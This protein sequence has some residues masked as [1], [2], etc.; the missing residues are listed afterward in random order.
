MCTRETV[1]MF[2]KRQRRRAG[3][4]DYDYW[5]LVRT[6]RS[7]RGPRHEVVARLGKLDGVEQKAARGWHDLDALLEGRSV[8]RQLEFGENAPTPLWRQVNL[9]QVRVERVRQF[10]RVYLG[11][12][13]WRRLKLH[14]YLADLM[15]PGREEIAWDLIAC[16]LAL[17]RFCAEPS[18]LG[19]A[20]RWYEHTALEDLLG[21]SAD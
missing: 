19:V 13:L 20:E 21:I 18:E 10:G 6:V 1:C 7:A 9:K 17:G 2:L 11:L 15:P 16:I 5:S 8:A 4:E 3:G 14:R 12:A